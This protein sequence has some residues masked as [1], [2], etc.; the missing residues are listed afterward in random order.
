VGPVGERRVAGLAEVRRE[1]VAA[2]HLVARAHLS[3]PT[4]L[5][6]L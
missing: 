2:A 5:P 3:H 1:V 6:H 4:H